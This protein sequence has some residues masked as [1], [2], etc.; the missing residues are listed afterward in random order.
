MMTPVR[1]AWL[2]SL[3]WIAVIGLESFGGSAENTSHLLYPLLKF[4]F[5]KITA[6]R[7]FQIHF[8]LRKA[9]HLLGYCVLSLA[10]YRS[11]WVT[12]AVR[13]G[14]DR[15]SLRQMIRSWDWRAALLS[16]A[17]TLVVAGLDEWHQSFNPLRGASIWDVAL[18]ECGGLMTQSVLVVIS[19]VEVVRQKG[20]SL[21]NGS[22][23][24]V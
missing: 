12:L 15:L 8:C 10:L 4:F 13:D 17:G 19:S 23:T 11:W 9:G 14:S 22:L 6:L 3:V 16:L 5:P 18:D 1:R 24:S 20:R 2:I 7:M 21:R